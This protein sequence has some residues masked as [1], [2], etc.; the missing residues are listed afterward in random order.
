MSSREIAMNHAIGFFPW[1]APS[2]QGSLR[3][4]TYLGLSSYF[5]ASGLCLGVAFAY[6][7]FVH[8]VVAPAVSR[9][10]MLG[11]GSPMEIAASL[12]MGGML[13]VLGLAGLL[14]LVS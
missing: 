14:G 11:V 1:I 12:K 7:L 9:D 5:Y 4:K 13:G 2:R 6:W 10:A 3:I 8:K